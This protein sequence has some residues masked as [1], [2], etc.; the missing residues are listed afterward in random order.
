MN[1]DLLRTF[2]E[3]SKTRHFGKAAENLCLTQSAV[4]FRIKQLE[5]SVGMSLFTRERNNILLTPSGERLLPHAENVLTSWQS[6]LQDVGAAGQL[7][8]QIA[9]GST[10]NLW[11]TFL[12]SLLPKVVDTFDGLNIR[13]EISSPQDLTR[14][15]LGGRI[16]IAVLLDPPSVTE[17]VLTKIGK[18]ELMFVSD[19]NW[20]A[21]E[22]LAKTKHIFV[23]WGTSV[24]VL[25]ARLFNQPHT[26]ILHTGQTHIALEFLMTYGGVALLPKVLVEQFVQSKQLFPIHGAESFVRE[27][28]AVHSDASQK[29][30][31][32]SSVVDLLKEEDLKPAFV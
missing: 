16:D 25:Q 15:L 31:I 12:Q 19:Q 30:D 1:T 17:L 4:S 20:A 26:P 13:T 22:E 23:D 28:Y 5:E 3:V 21:T 9:L 29:Q 2:M 18:V 27:V 11:D 32:V 10:S 24:N 8:M 14:A 6:A 7:D